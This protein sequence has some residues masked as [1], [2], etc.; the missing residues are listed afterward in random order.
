MRADRIK[1]LA[2]PKKPMGEQEADIDLEML[3]AEEDMMPEEE[4]DELLEGEEVG[5]PL[6]VLSDDELLAELKKRGLMSKSSPLGK[7]AESDIVIDEEVDY[8]DLPD[9]EMPLPP[10]KKK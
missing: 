4:G 5:G 9:D 6:D 3:G 2:M 8:N 7:A 1:G 10:K